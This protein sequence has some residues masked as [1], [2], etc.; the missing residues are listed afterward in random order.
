MLDSQDKARM[1]GTV[2]GSKAVEILLVQL[3]V[4]FSCP[5][6]GDVAVYF[7]CVVGIDCAIGEGRVLLTV[8]RWLV[9]I[10]ED[11][12]PANIFCVGGYS[13]IVFR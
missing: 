9:L 8:G 11:M 10:M 12:M 4:I 1:K 5:E 2:N 7:V 6:V 13:D 3:M